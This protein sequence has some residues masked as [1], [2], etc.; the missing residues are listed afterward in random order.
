[1]S[2][3]HDKEQCE[4]LQHT[5]TFIAYSI[6]EYLD[7]SPNSQKKLCML[8]FTWCSRNLVQYYYCLIVLVITLTERVPYVRDSNMVVKGPTDVLSPGS[9][10]FTGP[11]VIKSYMLPVFFLKFNFITQV[12]HGINNLCV[13]EYCGEHSLATKLFCCHIAIS[14]YIF[15]IYVVPEIIVKLPK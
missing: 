14:R 7:A 10:F 5:A 12:S 11:H 4:L 13:C 6:C 9:I 8:T 3:F 2:W 1:M 15:G